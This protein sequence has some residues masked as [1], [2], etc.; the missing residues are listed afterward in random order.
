MGQNGRRGFS[1]GVG[2]E[3]ADELIVSATRFCPHRQ[4]LHRGALKDVAEKNLISEK[5]IYATIGEVVAGKKKGFESPEQRIVCIPIGTGAMDV[6]SAY[7]VYEKARKQG[8]G[9]EFSFT[10]F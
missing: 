7:I 9:T 8:I 1:N 2:T 5:D 6:A 4:N 10:N 3:A